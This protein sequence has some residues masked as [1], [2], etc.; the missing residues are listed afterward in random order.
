LSQSWRPGP[1]AS[2]SSVSPLASWPAA[3]AAIAALSL[4]RRFG[5]MIV[6]NGA[7]KQGLWVFTT[8]T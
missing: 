2:W 3:W 7:R 8:I 4:W 6:T 1:D 5:P